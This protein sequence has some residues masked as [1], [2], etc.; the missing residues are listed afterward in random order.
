MH[1][2]P[3]RLVLSV[4]RAVAPAHLV[5][6]VPQRRPTAQDVGEGD[7][8]RASERAALPTVQSECFVK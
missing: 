7:E 2:V 4:S 5:Q 6:A 8:S 1:R 3:L